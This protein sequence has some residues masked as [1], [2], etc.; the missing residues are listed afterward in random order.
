[1]CAEIGK[2]YTLP[3]KVWGW[4]DFFNVFESLH[5]LLYLFDQKYN[6]T[7]FYF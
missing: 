1:M 2:E 7:F 3:S 6:T 4:Y 5:T